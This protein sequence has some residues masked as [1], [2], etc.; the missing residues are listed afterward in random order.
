[1]SLATSFGTVLCTSMH[2]C[3]SER[4]PPH[5]TKAFP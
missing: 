2:W 1:V 3:P 4:T 5:S